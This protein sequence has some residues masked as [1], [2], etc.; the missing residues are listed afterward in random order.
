[1]NPMH[2]AKKRNGI[3][4]TRHH[5]YVLVNTK[6]NPNACSTLFSAHQM[7]SRGNRKIF[8]TA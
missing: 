8:N 5:S 6:A 3:N 1:M 7:F 4:N 2:L